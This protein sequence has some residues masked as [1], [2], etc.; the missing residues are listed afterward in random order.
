MVRN[1]HMTSSITVEQMQE[2]MR[3]AAAWHDGSWRQ[4]PDK[5]GHQHGYGHF[6]ITTDDAVL[7]VCRQ[8]GIDTRFVSP[9]TILLDTQY[10][11]LTEWMSAPHIH[12]QG[13]L[14][15]NGMPAIN[16]VQTDAGPLNTQ[17]YG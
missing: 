9:F 5:F 13:N 2:V 17:Y 6:G 3:R 12:V 10:C 14:C 11:E 7:M 4:G 1:E 16:R 8:M 15:H